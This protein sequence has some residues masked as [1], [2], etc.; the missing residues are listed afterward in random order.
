MRCSTRSSARPSCKTWSGGYGPGSETKQHFEH[1]PVKK[2]LGERSC[3]GGSGPR[4]P[5]NKSRSR[6]L[7][8]ALRAARSHNLPAIGH[9]AY[10]RAD[11]PPPRRSTSRPMPTAGEDETEQGALEEHGL[12]ARNRHSGCAKT[13]SPHGRAAP[14]PPPSVSFGAPG[15]CTWGGW[16]SRG[17]PFNPLPRARDAPTE[18][19]G[20]T[21]DDLPLSHQSVTGSATSSHQRRR[22]Q[23]AGQPPPAPGEQA[24][25]RP[26]ASGFM[27]SKAAVGDVSGDVQYAKMC[28]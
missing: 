13:G 3:T 17:P 28:E 14:P 22:C 21:S 24:S 20:A 23:R 1:Q 12:G 7:A 25:P 6:A 8:C 18:S 15:C 4:A 27:I 11:S 5:K 9:T 19:D 10:G 16:G 26:S 2:K